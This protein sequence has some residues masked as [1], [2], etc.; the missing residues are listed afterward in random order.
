MGEAG[1]RV[2]RGLDG[3]HRAA[4]GMCSASAHL[5]PL[6]LSSHTHTGRGRERELGEW[7]QVR[8]T[9]EERKRAWQELM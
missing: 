3:E 8:E 7:Q 2:V 4:G 6:S 1:V 5:S 9:Q